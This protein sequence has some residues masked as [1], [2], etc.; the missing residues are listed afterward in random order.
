M[1]VLA[2]PEN[3]QRYC[4][5]VFLYQTMFA[6]LCLLY[7]IKSSTLLHICVFVSDYGLCACVCCIVSKSLHDNVHVVYLIK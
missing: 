4:M 5:Y 1:I 6:H 7:C 2:L 3:L